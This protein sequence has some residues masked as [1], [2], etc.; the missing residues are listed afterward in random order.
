[1]ETKE[2]KHYNFT[3]T[4]IYCGKKFTTDNFFVE[5]CDNCQ[6]EYV[7][8]LVKSHKNLKKDWQ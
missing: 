2:E 1:M 3:N 8:F 6:N 7:D 4:C 5:V